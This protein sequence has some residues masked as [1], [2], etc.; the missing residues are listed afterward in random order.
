MNIT[1]GNLWDS[2]DQ[3]ILV[4]TNAFVKKDGSLVMGRGA[5]KEAKEK[6][7]TLPYLLG[8]Q[9]TKHFKETKKYGVLIIPQM[10][11]AFQVKYNWWEDGDLELIGYSTQ[12]L[13]SMMEVSPFKEVS[14]SMNFP[15]IGNGRLRFEDVFE[16]VKKLNDRVTLY[17]KE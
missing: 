13:N 1:K 6:F 7:P 11:G 14:V 12:V 9:I 3:I 2:K 5:A 4:T 15:G 10:V 8:D 17:M 16:V